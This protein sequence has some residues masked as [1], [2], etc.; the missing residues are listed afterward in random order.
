M[1]YSSVVSRKVAH[2]LGKLGL[3]LYFVLERKINFMLVKSQIRK[4]KL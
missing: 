1:C 3:D 4:A 2:Y